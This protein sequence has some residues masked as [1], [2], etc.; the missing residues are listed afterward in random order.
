MDLGRLD[1]SNLKNVA[2][3]DG[4][5]ECVAVLQEHTQDVKHVV[6]HPNQDVGLAI[7][8]V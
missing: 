1:K 4:D 5:F 6:W 3:G 7:S 2:M 8:L